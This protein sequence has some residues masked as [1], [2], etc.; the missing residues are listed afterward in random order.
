M[1]GT[2]NCLSRTIVTPGSG[3][4]L[5]AASPVFTPNVASLKKLPI[6]A[7]VMLGAAVVRSE[8]IAS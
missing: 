3:L 2:P 5:P 1:C 4:S 6:C 8:Y 7:A